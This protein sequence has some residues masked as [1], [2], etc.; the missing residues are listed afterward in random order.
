MGITT[1]TERGRFLDRL[2]QFQRRGCN[3]LVVGDVSSEEYR[4]L[5]QRLFGVDTRDCCRVL[6]TT[7]DPA[8]NDLVDETRD[9]EWIRYD[10]EAESL[11]AFRRRIEATLDRLEPVDGYEPGECR[12]GVDSLS[13]LRRSG[14]ET[15][16]RHFLSE[17]TTMV[18]ER[19]GR[20]HYVC[21][22]SYEFIRQREL[23]V[24]FDATIECQYDVDG[25]AKHRWH[26]HTE[27]LTTDWIPLA[28]R[29]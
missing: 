3:L 19:R 24:L 18:A 8:D 27:E 17:I 6:V 29:C 7:R 12:I 1:R 14:S 9:I 22:H 28:A 13:A 5:S 10:A 25:E 16:F 21:D 23:D 15:A 26:V 4:L 20:G 2:A 11:D